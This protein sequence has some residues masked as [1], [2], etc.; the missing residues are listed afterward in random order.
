MISIERCG[1]EVVDYVKGAGRRRWILVAVPLVLIALAVPWA[2]SQPQEFRTISTVSVQPSTGFSGPSAVRS[3]VDTFVEVSETTA[4]LERAAA[5]AGVPLT[6][7]R[8]S[9][10]VTPVGGSPLVK[11]E[12]TTPDRSAGERITGALIRSALAIPLDSLIAQSKVEIEA[13]QADVERVDDRLAKIERDSGELLPPE[14]YRVAL[15]EVAR[16]ESILATGGSVPG[17]QTVS[18]ADLAQA[19]AVLKETRQEAQAYQELVVE[20]AQKQNQVTIVEARLSQFEERKNQIDGAVFDTTTK[21]VSNRPLLI[22][23]VVA[24]LVAGLLIASAGL[25]VIERL[26]RRR[27]PPES[28]VDGQKSPTEPSSDGGSPPGGDRGRSGDVSRRDPLSGAADEKTPYLRKAPPGDAR[29]TAGA[30][31]GK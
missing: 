22:Q 12:V 21:V 25:V 11:V 24:A 9:L 26:R 4:V 31:R 20:R 28:G 19:Q 30:T 18:E 5:A 7:F 8:G 29:P 6:D 14:A 2:L 17:G 23:A 27:S 16:I 15:A 1:V 10:S 3:V 13:V